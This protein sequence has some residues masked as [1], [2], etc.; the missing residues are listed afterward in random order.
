MYEVVRSERVGCYVRTVYLKCSRH[1]RGPGVGRIRVKDLRKDRMSSSV[2]LTLTHS[3]R[4]SSS[5]P[6][7]SGKGSTGEVILAPFLRNTDDRGS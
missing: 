1:K 7:I 3:H 2:F 4:K 6:E 5:T